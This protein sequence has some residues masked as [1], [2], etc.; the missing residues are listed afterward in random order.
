MN[1]DDECMV[2]PEHGCGRKFS[3]S[4]HLKRHSRTHFKYRPYVCPVAGCDS[5]FNRRDCWREHLRSVHDVQQ[6]PKANV[7]P[8]YPVMLRKKAPEVKTKRQDSPIELRPLLDYKPEPEPE[9]I[10]PKYLEPTK[11]KTEFK[12]SS[13]YPNF[14]VRF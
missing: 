13:F 11:N 10:C 14:M 6:I 2:C 12:F 3:R 5:S 8:P 1:D 7:P 9:L 4:S